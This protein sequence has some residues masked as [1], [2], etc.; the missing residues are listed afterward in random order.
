MLVAAT[1]GGG[2][3]VG[4]SPRGRVACGCGVG[5]GL[6]TVGRAAAGFTCGFRVGRFFA[7]GSLACEPSGRGRGVGCRCGRGCGRVWGFA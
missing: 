1:G 2:L 7:G 5:T 6:R 3:A 4:D